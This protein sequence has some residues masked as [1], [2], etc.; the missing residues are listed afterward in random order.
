MPHSFE[1]R[2]LVRSATREWVVQRR[3]PYVYKGIRTDACV[4]RIKKYG[5]KDN[6]VPVRFQ[7][8]TKN[9]RLDLKMKRFRSTFNSMPGILSTGRDI[10]QPHIPQNRA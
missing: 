8:A 9:G 2:P 4:I 1:S 5:K 7:R 10:R 6:F 3:K